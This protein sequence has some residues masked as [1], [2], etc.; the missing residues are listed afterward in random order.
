M[1]K[2]FQHHLQL[3]RLE[4]III[5]KLGHRFKMALTDQNFTIRIEKRENTEEKIGF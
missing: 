4:A 1:F 2:V 3:F 5:K